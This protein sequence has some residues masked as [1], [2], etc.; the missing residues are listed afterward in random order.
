[1]K[2]EMRFALQNR[3][4]ETEETDMAEI[5][6]TGENFEQEVLKSEK[7]VILDF[8]AVW[9]GP[10]QMQGPVFEEAAGR[11]SDRAVFGKVNVDE[12]PDLAQKYG[13]MSIPTL[14]LIQNGQ[15]AKKEVGFH[16]ASQI[17]D[18]LP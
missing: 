10:C 5:K 16:S 11:F 9:C 17:E 12:E 1:M 7:P 4:K 2:I 8:W 14:V 18:M 13:V 6:I 3:E 15:M